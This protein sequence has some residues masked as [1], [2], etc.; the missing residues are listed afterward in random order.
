MT[1]PVFFNGPGLSLDAKLV[2]TNDRSSIFLI[3]YSGLFYTGALG[4]VL[5]CFSKNRGVQ[6]AF[7]ASVRHA[8]KHALA[9]L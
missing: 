6:Q 5:G 8:A 2:S 3:Q 1:L 4:I 9:G 7:A